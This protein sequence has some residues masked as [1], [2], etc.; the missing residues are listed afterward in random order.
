MNR[1]IKIF[2]VIAAVLFVLSM[3][4]N[5]LVQ[6]AI[7]TAVSKAAHVP[8]HIGSTHVGLIHTSIDLRDIRLEN[9]RSFPERRMLEAPQVAI[10]FDLPAFFKGQI[11]FQE[12]KLNIRELVVIKNRDGNV[13]VNAL[14]PSQEERSKPQQVQANGKAPV[15]QID[16]LELTIGRVVYKDYSQGGEPIT[17]NFDIDIQN[18]VYSNIHNPTEVVSLIMFEAL[19]R[20]TL[21]RLANLDTG[22]FKEGASEVLT[23]GLGLMGDGAGKLEST[24]KGLLSLFK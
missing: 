3:T 11:H 21:S 14:K 10:A 1:I 4:K 24:A 19:T 23:D 22:I 5:F 6:A 18:R 7:E 17:Q 16:K 8:V 12:V 20:T 15:L 13:N 2:V 9:P